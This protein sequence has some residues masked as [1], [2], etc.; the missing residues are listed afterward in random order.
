MCCATLLQGDEPA[1]SCQA[2]R[3]AMTGEDPGVELTDVFFAQ[4]PVRG[5][6]SACV[7]W[8]VDQRHGVGGVVDAGGGGQCTE[9]EERGLP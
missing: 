6:E 8:R 7:G 9:S 4:C 5:V 2:E 3:D 1:E